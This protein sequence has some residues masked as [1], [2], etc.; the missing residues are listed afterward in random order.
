MSKVELDTITSGYNLS[1]I[2][3]N[4]QKLE[5][6]LNNNVLYRKHEVGESNH[7]E[8]T[9]DMDSNDIIN[10]KD[11]SVDRLF[12]D[13][14]EVI[15]E[16]LVN[17]AALNALNE[18]KEDLSGSE[19]SSLVGFI[20]LGTGATPRTALDKMRDDINGK[21]F[22]VSVLLP[23]NSSQLQDTFNKQYGEISPEIYTFTTPLKIPSLSHFE[24]KKS[25]IGMIGNT[26][27]VKNALKKTSNT[28]VDITNF[29]TNVVTPVDCLAYLDPF[30]IDGGA[31][32]PQHSSLERLSF[33][34]NSPT[35]NHSGI[36]IEQGG[37]W[38]F[39]DLTFTN[40][41]HAI[42]A[43]EAWLTVVES[44]HAFG[45]FTWKGGTS[46]T[47][48]NC[49]TG[50]G[51]GGA[52]GGYDFEALI[53]STMNSCASDGATNS[54]YRFK[55]SSMTLNG[56]GCENATTS[57]AD[58]GTALSFDGGNKIVLNNFICVPQNNQVIS[59]VT[60][61]ANE[62][63]QFNG[64]NFYFSAVTGINCPDIYITGDGSTVIFRDF[65]FLNGT[66]NGPL[67]QFKNGVTTSK[68]IVHYGDNT[69]IFTSN[70]SGTT[71]ID[72][73]YDGGVWTPT[74][75]FGGGSTGMTYAVRTGT[76]TKQG[77]LVTVSG[78]IQ[79]SA[80]GTSTGV[81]V[82]GGMP[83]FISEGD[84]MVNPALAAS[85]TGGPI[86]G[87]I[88]K[89]GGAA[90]VLNVRTATGDVNATEANFTN[91]T[92]LRFSFTYLIV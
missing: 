20:Q 42:Y 15:P 2:N 83:A 31:A 79:L 77:R 64:G 25:G 73:F 27:T 33:Q 26:A 63:I 38:S 11:I 69:K 74:L 82:L 68:V 67:V 8:V 81:A 9:L 13:G 88:D 76:W 22:G 37:N 29:Q 36:Y 52:T 17:E 1:K 54:A 12:I 60:V 28:T 5:G 34:G 51:P 78:R 7:M 86:F 43:K 44:C 35:N 19:G 71:L 61:S 62:E 18:F 45:K 57:T 55:F 89:G 65:T 41:S 92:L 70:G 48:T 75:T 14:E 46:V 66:K 40:V 87:I 53:Y 58:S 23:D 84:V 32:Y 72:S 90:S 80:K 6:E 85:I 16:D 30:W 39:K 59:P 56:C 4:F 24:G 47:F 50:S 91:G 21:D 49:W 10:V 3:N